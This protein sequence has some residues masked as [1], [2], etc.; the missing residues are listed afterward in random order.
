MEEGLGELPFFDAPEG[1][2][3]NQSTLSSSCIARI[4]KDHQDDV[5]IT[6]FYEYSS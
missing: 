3:A 4:K 5:I 1:E 2:E 6:W